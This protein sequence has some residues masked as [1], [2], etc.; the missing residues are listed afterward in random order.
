[1]Q[2]TK[3]SKI[4]IITSFLVVILLCLNSCKGTKNEYYVAQTGD[5]N[6]PGTLK[7]PFLTIQKA[8]DVML[9]GDV[10][11]VRGGTYREMVVPPKSGLA[12][13]PISFM[14]FQKEEVI[15]DG[16]DPIQGPWVLHEGNIYKT[17]VNISFDQLFLNGKMLV[18]ARW[19]NMSFPD[20]LWT[21]SCWATAKEG[22]RYGKMVDDELA[23]TGID[24]TGAIAVLNVAHQFVSWTRPVKSHGAGTNTFTYE[25]NLSPITSYADKTKQWEDDIYYLTGKLEALDMPGEW[26]LDRENME[27]YLWTP[28]GKNPDSYKIS[29]KSRYYAFNITEK[30]F[31]FISGFQFSGTTILLKDVNHSKVENCIFMYPSFSREFNDPDA[32]KTTSET[33]LSGNNNIFRNNYMAFSQMSGLKIMGAGNIIDNNIIHDVAWNGDGCAISMKSNAREGETSIISGNTAYN[34]GY[35]IL[36]PGGSGGWIVKYNHFYN[37]A[38]ISKDCAAIQTGSW[39]IRGS[40]IHHNWV[41]DCF[42]SREQQPGGLAGG[43]GI[44]GDDQTRGLTIHHNVVW[45]CGRDGIIVKGDSNR[46]YNNTVFNIGSNGR[47]GN[48]ISLHVEPEPFKPWRNQAPLLE[49]QNLSS[50]V[51]NNAAFNISGDRQ[52]NPFTPEK[53]LQSNYLSKDLG[54]KDPD[55]FDF[56]PR[57]GSPLIDAGAKIQDFTENFK[58]KFPDIGAYEYGDTYWKPGSSLEPVKNF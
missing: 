44:R 12:N 1:M 45:N 49:I 32:K 26:F 46:V 15:L 33:I 56:S 8:A 51:I 14:S 39:H 23:K 5:D 29:N 35:S 24:W 9:P 40:V 20:Q 30:E 47:E 43:L 36:Q 7:L 37:A 54:L 6:D 50:L 17:T 13:K 48:Y 19:P 4:K 3:R 22:S 41:H 58:G 2:H 16:S 57:E 52:G 31:I 55:N 53:N 42:A 10:C 21:R 18:E 11:Y 25:K 34:S 27:L 28:D 38:L